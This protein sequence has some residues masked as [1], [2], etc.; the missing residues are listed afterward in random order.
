M[1]GFSRAPA[2]LP[3]FFP[4]D[5]LGQKSI[6]SIPFI[7][8]APA[9]VVGSVIVASVVVIIALWAMF[10]VLRRELQHSLFKR[11]CVACLLG[12]ST[13]IFHFTASLGTTYAVDPSKGERFVLF[14]DPG[15]I[16][17]MT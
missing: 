10:L 3:P 2:N 7:S 9:I 6:T 11:A 12:S 13:S 5:Y 4:T 1:I 8:Y 17:L 16:A 15:A 14:A